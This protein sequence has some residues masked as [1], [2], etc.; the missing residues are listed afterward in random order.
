VDASL[1]GTYGQVAFEVSPFVN[2]IHDYIYGFLRGD[3]ILD[4]PVRQ[5]APTNAR[6]FGFETGV[7]VQPL[8]ALAL[9]AQAD[10]VNAQ[11]TR[12]SQPLPFIPPLR[13]LLRATYQKQRFMGLIEE[14]MAARQTRLGDGDTPTP[15]Y[16]ITNVGVGVRIAGG[17]LVHDFRLSCDNLFDQVYRDNLSVVKDF[18]PQ[19]GRAVR[20]GYEMSY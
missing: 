15:G 2:Y 17:G 14:R 12:L 3:T 4:F 11:D 18:I 9:R 20:L 8:Q 13:G 7:T 10:Y 6:L 19:P 16:A 5:F 1:R